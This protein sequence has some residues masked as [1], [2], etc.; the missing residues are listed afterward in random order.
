MASV[1]HDFVFSLQE[2]A[3]RLIDA[4]AGPAERQSALGADDA[5]EAFDIDA[6]ELNAIVDVR[7][8]K[9]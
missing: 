9:R 4:A 8:A 2:D 3:Q 6:F 5:V 1:A 7:A